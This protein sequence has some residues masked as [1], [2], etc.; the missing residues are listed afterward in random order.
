MGKELGLGGACARGPCPSPSFH[1]LS[2]KPEAVW[3]LGSKT[4]LLLVQLRPSGV[5]PAAGL[6]RLELGMTSLQ[7]LDCLF[8]PVAVAPEL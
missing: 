1:F 5:Q 8:L 4:V 7:N 3:R 2:L 6:G